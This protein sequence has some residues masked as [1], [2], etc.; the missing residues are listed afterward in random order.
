MLFRAF[1]YNVSI[2][3]IVTVRKYITSYNKY[4]AFGNG[5]FTVKK[6][7]VMGVFISFQKFARKG[8]YL[9]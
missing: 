3:I 9:L 7:H 5:F 4:L 1:F 8:F 2:K 6:K